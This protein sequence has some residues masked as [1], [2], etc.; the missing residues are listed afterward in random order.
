MMRPLQ[1][2]TYGLLTALLCWVLPGLAQFGAK[3]G[4]WRSYGGEEGSTR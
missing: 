2:V 4:Q 3:N 1:L